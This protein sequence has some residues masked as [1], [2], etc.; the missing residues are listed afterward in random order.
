[1]RSMPDYGY[2]NARLRGM[3]TRLLVSGEYETMLRAGSIRE[4]VEIVHR[5]RLKPDLD[6]ALVRY[7]GIEALEEAFRSDFIK[8]CRKVLAI[9]EKGQ[10]KL[11]REILRRWDVF[12]IKTVLRG[13]H[14]AVASDTISRSLIPAGELDELALAELAQQPGVKEVVDLLATWDFYLA[15]PLVENLEGFFFDHNLIRLELGLDRAYFKK[16]LRATIGPGK[17]R[18]L[19]NELL[20]SEIDIANIMAKIRLIPDEIDTYV[21]TKKEKSERKK[22]EKAEA[23]QKKREAKKTLQKPKPPPLKKKEPP[24][25]TREEKH[26]LPPVQDYFIPGGKELGGQKLDDLLRVKSM[27]KLFSLLSETSFR[28]FISAEMI[29]LERIPDLGAFERSIE[30]DLT[31][32]LARLY[33]R[34]PIGIAMAISYIW[35]KYNQLVNLRL[36]SRGKEF[37]I[38]A[39]VLRGEMAF[40]PGNGP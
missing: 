39:N 22:K 29:E 36:I 14:A 15:E 33:R 1:M 40:H 9:S 27:E 17:N 24:P 13:T 4:L 20:R 3:K 28:K 34:E 38:P 18:R 19:V 26:P 10:K 35:M 16:G 8:G 37:S 32:R 5:G 21:E 12:N 11:I 6:R 25:P 30:V 31:G 23:R 7:Q 2:L